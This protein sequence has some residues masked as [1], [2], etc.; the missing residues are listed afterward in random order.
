MADVDDRFA[1]VGKKKLMSLSGDGGKKKKTSSFFPANLPVATLSFPFRSSFHHRH[2]AHSTIAAQSL[3][4]MG[5]GE[6]EE[7]QQQQGGWT[8]VTVTLSC[9]LFLVAGVLEVGGGWLVWQA[10]REVRE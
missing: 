8:P 10:L 3:Y 2:T 4:K 9:V 6:S 5:G 7:E 1:R